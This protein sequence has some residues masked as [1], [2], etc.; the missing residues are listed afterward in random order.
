[1][2]SLDVHFE[3]PAHRTAFDRRN[4]DA[5]FIFNQTIAGHYRNGRTGYTDV[6]VLLITWDRDDMNLKKSEASHS[7]QDGYVSAH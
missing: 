5:R 4:D 6:S 1:M 7:F 2:A 3:A